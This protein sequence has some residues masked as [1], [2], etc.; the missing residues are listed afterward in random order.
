MMDETVMV[1]H[2][3]MVDHSGMADHG[4]MVDHGGIEFS[5]DTTL[6]LQQED[7]VGE[8]ESWDRV[9][10]L[11]MAIQ[12]V[13]VDE[14]PC[15]RASR[16]FNLPESTVKVN[17]PGRAPALPADVEQSVMK[18]AADMS[19]LGHSYSTKEF[20]ELIAEVQQY[21]YPEE[22]AFKDD[23][24]HRSYLKRF[25]TRCPELTV[26]KRKVVPTTGKILGRNEAMANYY[27]RLEELLDDNDIK[28]KPDHIF[29]MEES[30]IGHGDSTQGEVLFPPA[31][32]MSLDE[33][34]DEDREM[35]TVVG[36]GSAHG[37][38]LPPFIVYKG[39]KKKNE[40]LDGAYPGTG[41]AVSPKRLDELG[42]H[43][44]VLVSRRHLLPL[45]SGRYCCSTTA[46]RHTSSPR[47]SMWP[48]RWASCCL[49][50][51]HMPQ[52]LR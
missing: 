46:S 25:M 29:L 10:R 18:H 26:R 37:N 34:E 1:D 23:L 43:G 24:P 5:D 35:T 44:E 20:L 50:C 33:D 27:Y 8:D 22:S 36:C 49:S 31:A 42:H 17:R 47:L 11:K 6:Q 14:I 9:E 3:G 21:L 30:V 19:D 13:E 28:D 52:T 48:V 15:R 12:A 40:L 16:L 32:K 41:C 45:W 51:H 2:G 4:G 39:F 7:V 38:P